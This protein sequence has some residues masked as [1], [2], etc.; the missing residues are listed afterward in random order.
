[1][2]GE[3]EGVYGLIGAFAEPHAAMAMARHL[4]RDGFRRFEIYSPLPL[5]ETTEFIA[6]EPRTWLALIM[7]AAAIGGA[8]IGFAMQYVIAV[9]GYPINIGGRPLNSWPAFI[10]TAW[11]ICA[12]F[13]VY[14]AFAAFL[15]FCRL[16]KLYHPV[17][18]APGFERASQDRTFVSVEIDDPRFDAERL[19]AM[20]HECRA[21]AIAEVPQ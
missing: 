6:D 3:A 19:A 5:D 4:R 10:P 17:F 1:M 15:A 9:I 11:E 8:V 21:L 12:F 16:P 18:N 2:S 13:T 7:F 14:I 20:F